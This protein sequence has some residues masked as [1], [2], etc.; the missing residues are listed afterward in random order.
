M[1]QWEED[2]KSESSR[3]SQFSVVGW[4]IYKEKGFMTPLFRGSTCATNITLPLMRT[5]GQSQ[6]QGSHHRWE[7]RAQLGSHGPF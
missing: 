4:V 2:P 5:L 3:W 7:A 6:Q 1:S